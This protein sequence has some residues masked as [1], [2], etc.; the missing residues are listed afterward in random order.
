[1]S[2][3][4]HTYFPQL[5][6][7]RTIAVVMVMMAHWLPYRW[8]SELGFGPLGVYLFFVL[9]G[10]LITRI[11]LQSKKQ[12]D[13]KQSTVGQQLKT[14]YMRRIL[15]IFPMY[16]LLIG[17]TYLFTPSTRPGLW[18]NLTYTSNFYL[19]DKGDWAGP[20][21]HYWSLAVEEQFYLIWPLLL[22]LIPHRYL[23]QVLWGSILFGLGSRAIMQL[24]G[25]SYLSVY[26]LTPACW[27]LFA[28]GGLLAY[29]QLYE[30]EKLQIWLNQRAIFWGALGLCIFTMTGHLYL[31]ES[32]E[33]M[34]QLFPKFFFAWFVFWLL[35]RASD[36]FQGTG[37][38]FLQHPWMVYLGRISYSLYLFHNFMD[39]FFLGIT[40]PEDPF[41]R[42]FMYFGGAVIVSTVAYYV[43]ERPF[44]RLKKYF[45]YRDKTLQPTSSTDH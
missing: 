41:W 6:G 32:M 33:F 30:G 5:D 22:F 34:H 40:F 12:L 10:F 42:F 4:G 35:G 11:L 36:G 23:K 45:P 13:Q 24:L 29:M 2:N 1:M 9:S 3:I 14:F 8:L 27:D 18:W 28:V 7:L 19:I 26:I 37:G 16:Y 17:I 39:G 25:A 31:P 20:M 38:K 15:R 21:S 44:Q 43:V